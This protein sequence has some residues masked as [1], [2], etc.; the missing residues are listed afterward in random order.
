MSSNIENKVIDNTDKINKLKKEIEELKA[1]IDMVDT[2][3]NTLK[4]NNRK[5]IIK[6]FIEKEEIKKIA[7]DIN[8]T[9]KTVT[10]K[11]SNSIK[12]LEK[13]YKN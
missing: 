12:Y 8:R 1:K 9:E 4:S 11:L 5:V 2:Y 13:M 3:I 10:R 7:D 6:Y